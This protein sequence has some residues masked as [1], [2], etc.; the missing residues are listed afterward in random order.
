M[1]AGAQVF[2]LECHRPADGMEPEQLFYSDSKQPWP[3]TR[4]YS[5]VGHGVVENSGRVVVHTEQCS[6]TQPPQAYI[7]PLRP[8]F[9]MG[10]WSE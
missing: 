10:C 6:I 8:I 9:W 7:S 3:T 1:V 5:I 4:M 2:L